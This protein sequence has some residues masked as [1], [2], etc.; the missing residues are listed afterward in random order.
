MLYKYNDDERP[1]NCCYDCKLDY[2][3]FPDMIIPDELWEVINPTHLV[4]VLHQQYEG[5][6]LLC[7]TCIARRLH[8]HGLWY[9]LELYKLK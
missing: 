3:D 2:V 5:A 6:G 8:H 4:D 7:P 1:K 9:N